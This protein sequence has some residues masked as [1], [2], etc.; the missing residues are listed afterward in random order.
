M[1]KILIGICCGGTI[2]AP[3]VASL[4]GA[5]DILKNEGD[6]SFKLSIQIGGDKARG[7]NNLARECVEG[8][9]DFLMSIDND[10]VFP[11]DAVRRLIEHDKDIVGAN[12]SV[13]GNAVGNDPRE[14][15]VKIANEAGEK[16]SL[17]LTEVPKTLFKCHALGNGFTLYKGE[18]F[19]KMEAPWFRVVEEPNGDWS[20]EDVLFHEDAQKAGFEVWCNPKIHM[21]HIGSYRYEL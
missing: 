12:Y 18:V 2:Q 10:M 17:P 14:C 7:M 19:K 15:V 21:G 16:I 1:K 5:I 13:R 9:F 3:T 8:D 11:I 6:Y 20:G 4:V